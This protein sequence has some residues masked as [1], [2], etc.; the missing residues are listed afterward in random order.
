[1]LYETLLKKIKKRRQ[2]GRVGTDGITA[3]EVSTI[4]K[5]VIHRILLYSLQF[6][7]QNRKPASIRQTL[8]SL[9]FALGHFSLTAFLF[10]IY[11]T[12]IFHTSLMLFVFHG[13]VS[14]YL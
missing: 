11:H 1:M 8:I 7:H 3:F 4:L 12:F 2:L 5:S 10:C 9:Y 6:Y 13:M 14:F